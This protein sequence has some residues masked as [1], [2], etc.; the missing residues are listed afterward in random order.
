MSLS[1]TRILPLSAAN[2][3]HAVVRMPQTSWYWL[4]DLVQLRYPGGYK[5]LVREFRSAAQTPAEL[6][7]ILRR[8][9][10]AHC[11]TQM[12]YLYNLSNDNIPP[13]DRPVPIKTSPAHPE[14]ADMSAA[15]P[16]LYQLFKFL[17]HPTYLTTVWERRNY[18]LQALDD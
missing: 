10:E 17:P 8:E 3:A 16:S 4:D 7:A 13:K 14:T 11:Q 18:H 9:A 6:E 5:D 12:G 1:E 2:A 15:M